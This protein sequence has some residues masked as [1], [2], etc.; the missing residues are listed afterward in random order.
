[1]KSRGNTCRHVAPQ[2]E[3]TL[4]ILLVSF[5]ATQH[6]PE[7]SH[8]QSRNTS[9]PRT[10]IWVDI[11]ECALLKFTKAVH[12]KCIQGIIGLR[13]HSA[14]ISNI[15]QCPIVPRRTRWGQRGT[16]RTHT[17]RPTSMSIGIISVKQKWY[18]IH[19]IAIL[20]NMCVDLSSSKAVFCKTWQLWQDSKTTSV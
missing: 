18:H 5:D 4:K 7:T 12:H 10:T 15:Q 13:Q 6:C 11:K 1:M 2:L 20:K 8:D 14:S 16:D 19:K 9:I 17:K 3:G